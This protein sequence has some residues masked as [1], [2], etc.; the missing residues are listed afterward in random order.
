MNR[1]QKFY[2][3]KLKELQYHFHDHLFYL[4]EYDDGDDHDVFCQFYED[5]ALSFL[6]QIGAMV[7]VEQ[8]LSIRDAI[9]YVRKVPSGITP[10][11]RVSEVSGP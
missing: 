2:K 3:V 6:Y 8:F 7:H 10:I 9:V 4:N 1:H 11:P 5:Q